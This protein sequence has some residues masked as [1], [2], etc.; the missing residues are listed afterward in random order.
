MFKQLKYI[1]IV[2]TDT[3]TVITTM[4]WDLYNINDKIVHTFPSKKKER[5]IFVAQCLQDEIL[6]HLI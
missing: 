6:K 4:I 2:V 5:K 1:D 3:T